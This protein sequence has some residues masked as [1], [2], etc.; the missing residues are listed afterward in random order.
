M[1]KIIKSKN[2][3]IAV[4]LFLAVFIVA[5]AVLSSNLHNTFSIATPTSGITLLGLSNV[6]VYSNING[7]SGTWWLATGVLGGGQS[8]NI[9]QPA[10]AFIPSN[11]NFTC[12]NSSCQ[13][14]NLQITQS[15]VGLEYPISLAGSSI[16][17]YRLTYLNNGN[18]YL[19]YQSCIGQL[20]GGFA[21]QTTPTSQPINFPC[22]LGR[23]QTY[24]NYQQS[25]QN[26]NGIYL[27]INTTEVPGQTFVNYVALIDL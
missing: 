3:K 12:I 15:N 13:N 20:F 25:C 24:N 11:S 10:Q 19:T 8:I 18:G 17:N 22:A 5:F 14:D 4:V 21:S 16:E 1:K 23:Q 26:A 7:D 9:D 6:G 27:V 2:N